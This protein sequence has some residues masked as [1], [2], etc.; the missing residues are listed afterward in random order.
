MSTVTWT[1]P[2]DTRK[3]QGF[4]DP[5]LPQII[6]DAARLDRWLIDH[7]RRE[8]TETVNKRYL[9][10]HGPV[11]DGARLDRAIMDLAELDR[12]RLRKEGGRTDVDVNPELIWDADNSLIDTAIDQITG[13]LK[14]VTG[15]YLSQM[16][17]RSRAY[18]KLNLDEQGRV[19]DALVNNGAA[20]IDPVKKG[21]LR[22]LVSA[23]QIKPM[24]GGT[25]HENDGVDA[26]DISARVMNRL[27]PLMEQIILEEMEK[28]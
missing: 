20:I 18:G 10:Q 17:N 16:H 3:V 8:R 19:I 27:Y 24:P 14:R 28:C 4:G 2:K 23:Q 1:Q 12:L 26:A 11:R 25:K 13:A 21:Y 5:F 7:C 22:S 15:I 6:L 9:H